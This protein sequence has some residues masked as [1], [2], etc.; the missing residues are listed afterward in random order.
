MFIVDNIVLIHRLLFY[1]L[2]HKQ[3][4]TV[5]NSSNKNRSQVCTP[6]PDHPVK[7]YF[8]H[9]CTEVSLHKPTEGDAVQFMVILIWIFGIFLLLLYRIQAILVLC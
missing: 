8:V 1:D 6:G 4:C 2:L 3:L 5:I 9:H 7:I